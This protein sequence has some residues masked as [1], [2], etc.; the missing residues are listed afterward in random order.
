MK[1][2]TAK[3]KQRLRARVARAGHMAAVKF[4]REN[5]APTVSHRRTRARQK[6]VVYSTFF[7][8]A[9]TEPMRQLIDEIWSSTFEEENQSIGVAHAQ[10]RTGPKTP[11]IER[12]VSN[13][14]YVYHYY[15]NRTHQSHT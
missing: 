6:P 5:Y 3:C 2:R 14:R 8:S 11:H 13:Y 15:I 12:Q 7:F 10:T 9:H 4:A 1:F